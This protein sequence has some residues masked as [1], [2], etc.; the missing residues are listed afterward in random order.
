M[1]FLSL[2]AGRIRN[3]TLAKF[4]RTLPLVQLNGLWQLRDGPEKNRRVLKNI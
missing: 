3:Y 2:S 1:K 4:T